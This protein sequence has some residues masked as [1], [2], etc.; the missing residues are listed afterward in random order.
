MKSLDDLSPAELQDIPGLPL[1]HFSRATGTSNNHNRNKINA[2]TLEARKDGDLV[3]IVPTPREHMA[4]LPA[5]R[6]RRYQKRQS[7]KQPA[8]A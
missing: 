2:G 4:S 8:S 6:A 3:R 5:Y 7:E 1:R